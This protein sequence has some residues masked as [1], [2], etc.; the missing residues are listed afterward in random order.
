M[1]IRPKLPLALIVITFF[2]SS[3]GTQETYHELA[4]D[5]RPTTS[6]LSPWDGTPEGM[7]LI[8]FLNNRQTT[9]EILDIDIGLDRR[10]AGNLI[11][12]RNGGDGYYG[13]SDDDLYESIAEVDRVRWVGPRTIEKMIHFINSM[14][15]IPESD[16]SLGT[17]DS[18]HF[19]V[20]QASATLAFAN[21]ASEDTLDYELNLDKRAVE[22]IIYSRPISSIAHLAGLYYVGKT[23]LT[24]LKESSSND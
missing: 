10:A 20:S 6:A 7:A 13:T 15:M 2:I 17:W 5:L 3:C 8:D 1:A 24:R 4:I 19:T 9:E 12:H 11:V 22:S 23:A 16:E 14:E 18:V 21:S